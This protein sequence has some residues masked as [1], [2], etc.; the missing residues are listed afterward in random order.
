MI[1]LTFLILP[2]SFHTHLILV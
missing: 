1:D 2:L